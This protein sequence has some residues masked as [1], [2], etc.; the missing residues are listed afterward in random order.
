MRLEDVGELMNV[1]RERA[2][3]IEVQALSKLGMATG[4]DALSDYV[5]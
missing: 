4:H 3:Q 5:E 2:R 1:T